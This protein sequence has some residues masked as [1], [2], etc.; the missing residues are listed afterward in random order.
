MKKLLL[1]NPNTSSATTSGMLAVA[2]EEAA[3]LIEIE[4][5]TVGRGPLMVVDSAGL[6]TAADAVGELVAATDLSS[7][8]GIIIGGFGDPGLE[9]VRGRICVPATG[10]AEA[11]FSEAA[12]GGRRFSVVMTAPGLVAAIEARAAT[13]GCRAQLARIH[14]VCQGAARPSGPDA[15]QAAVHAACEAAIREDG[16]DAV[17]IGGGPLAPVARRL[18]SLLA[19]PVVEPIPA[20]VRLALARA[21]QGAPAVAQ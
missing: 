15:V 10:I 18:R 20:S 6:Q 3:G 16:I 9:R 13:Y 5:A 14:V 21:Q 2:A 17:V 12:A 8:A 19:V 1:I 7:Y 4:G 11:A